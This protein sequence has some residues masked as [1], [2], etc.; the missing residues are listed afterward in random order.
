MSKMCRNSLSVSYFVTIGTGFLVVGDGA[1]D[2]FVGAFVIGA[3]ALVGA[4]VVWT[5]A[6]E[7]GALLHFGSFE[8]GEHASGGR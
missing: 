4:L 6:F 7:A 3:G 8:F 2:A 5:G 1:F